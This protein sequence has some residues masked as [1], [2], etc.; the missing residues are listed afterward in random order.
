MTRNAGKEAQHLNQLKFTWGDS[1]GMSPRL[2]FIAKGRPEDHSHWRGK[3]A[4]THYAAK[5]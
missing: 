2:V 5:G 1:P 3:Q 4:I